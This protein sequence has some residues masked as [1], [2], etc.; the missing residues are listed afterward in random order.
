MYMFF[1]QC[2]CVPYVL[3][4][5]LLL[6]K[7]FSTI[8]AGLKLDSWIL[9]GV[10]ISGDDL[11]SRQTLLYVW[12]RRGGKVIINNGGGGKVKVIIECVIM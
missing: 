12:R 9:P 5:P 2:A 4:E 10:F 1:R 7:I 3:F 6:S 11:Y 8:L